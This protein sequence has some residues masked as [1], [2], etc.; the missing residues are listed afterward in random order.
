MRLWWRRAKVVVQRQVRDAGALPE[1]GL[2]AP[3]SLAA[4]AAGDPRLDADLGRIAARLFGQPAQFVEFGQCGV[5]GRIGVHDPA[6]AECGD[7]FQRLVDVTAEPHR[8][9]PVHRQ[10]G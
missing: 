8:D 9:S 3:V 5:A 6:V 2:L 7:A 1:P 10:A 4:G